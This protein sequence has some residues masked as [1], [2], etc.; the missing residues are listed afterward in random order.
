MRLRREGEGMEVAGR[1]FFLLY[2]FCSTDRLTFGTPCRSEASRARNARAAESS[3]CT[4][5]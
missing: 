2:D 5:H 4:L 3:K 1:Y